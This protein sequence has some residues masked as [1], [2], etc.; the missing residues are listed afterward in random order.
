MFAPPPLQ[1]QMEIPRSLSHAPAL[2][3]HL[4][5]YGSRVE[6]KYILYGFFPPSGSF[7][8][9]MFQ[10][11]QAQDRR[12]LVIIVHGFLTI[13]AQHYLLDQY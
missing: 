6:P 3:Y 9:Y 12:V 7:P 10:K 5:S 4:Q 11:V 8:G 2:R 1:T 13:L